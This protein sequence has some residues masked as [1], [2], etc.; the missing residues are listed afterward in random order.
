MSIDEKVLEVLHASKEPLKSGEIVDQTGLSKA[1]VD[2]A[3]K[4]LKNE[5]KITSPKRCF[6]SVSK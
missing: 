6:Y 5:G 3:I 1:D 4:A 2:K